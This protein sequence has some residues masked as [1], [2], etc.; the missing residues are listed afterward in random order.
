[1]GLIAVTPDHMRLD[2]GGDAVFGMRVLWQPL[3]IDPDW[4]ESFLV[5]VVGLLEDPE[6]A[7]T[8]NCPYCAMQRAIA[9]QELAA[10]TLSLPGNPSGV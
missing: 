7:G 3:A 1:M 6:P 10:S 2:E 9:S 5:E 4:W 8:H